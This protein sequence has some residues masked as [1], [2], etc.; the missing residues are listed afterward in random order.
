MRRK[1]HTQRKLITDSLKDIRKDCKGCNFK[2]RKQARIKKN[3]GKVK[4]ESVMSPQD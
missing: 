3:I 2:K 1:L 4:Y